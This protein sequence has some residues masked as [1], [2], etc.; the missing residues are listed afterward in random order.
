MRSLVSE[1][2]SSAISVRFRCDILVI[3][4]SKFSAVDVEAC[5]EEDRV[6]AVSCESTLGEE[7]KVDFSASGL[8]IAQLNLY[9]LARE[10]S[11]T[12]AQQARKMGGARLVYTLNRRLAATCRPRPCH[13]MENSCGIR[14]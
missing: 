12:E 1:T 4:T 7:V 5:G 3:P 11:G 8:G 13:C 10:R 9:H 14:R 6:V 2:H